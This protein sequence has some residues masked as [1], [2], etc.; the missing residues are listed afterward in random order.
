M[1]PLRLNKLHG[2]GKI[3]FW[4]IVFLLPAT[5]EA[6]PKQVVAPSVGI[7]YEAEKD[8]LLYA[9]GYRFLEESI[10]RSFSPIALD[11]NAFQQRLARLKGTRCNG[12]CL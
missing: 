6:Q 12:V 3:F 11:W 4:I 2:V 1:N 9:S 5:S 10:G 8:S 7:I